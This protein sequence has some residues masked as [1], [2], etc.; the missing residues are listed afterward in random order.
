MLKALLLYISV[1]SS[2]F[3]KI[4]SIDLANDASLS[5]ELVKEGAGEVFIDLGFDIIKIP[6]T[7]IVQIVD[8]ESKKSVVKG[9]FTSEL[10]IESLG[11]RKLSSLRNLVDELGEAVVLIRKMHLQ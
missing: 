5:G 7:S 9:T 8:Q 2:I 10:F 11:S 6:R 3:A 1:S 4:V